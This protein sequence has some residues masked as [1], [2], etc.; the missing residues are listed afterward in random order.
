MTTEVLDEFKMDAW[1]FR[2]IP[3]IEENTS[4][5]SDALWE[6]YRDLGLIEDHEA[7]QEQ[8][9]NPEKA[10]KDKQL[11][12]DKQSTLKLLK[13]ESEDEEMELK[14]RTIKVCYRGCSV[15][16]SFLKLKLYRDNFHDL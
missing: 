10:V 11:T 6:S 9:E 15:S 13:N 12:L 4:D 8:S 14:Q 16:K 7:T 5:E 1:C 3:N 2:G